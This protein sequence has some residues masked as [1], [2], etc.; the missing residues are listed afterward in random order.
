MVMKMKQKWSNYT[1]TA[2][3]KII[4]VLDVYHTELRNSQ[5]LINIASAERDGA[6]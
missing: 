4:Q 5:D 3:T 2:W 6:L 1:S